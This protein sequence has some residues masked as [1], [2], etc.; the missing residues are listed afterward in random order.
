MSRAAVVLM[1][2]VREA[3]PGSR[4][5]V[6]GHQMAADV[7]AQQNFPHPAAA[8]AHAQQALEH[9]PES[10]DWYITLQDYLTRAGALM[11]GSSGRMLN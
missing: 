9:T 6:I 5:W 2:S 3:A 10:D 7:M 4:D 11:G 8:Y 1:R